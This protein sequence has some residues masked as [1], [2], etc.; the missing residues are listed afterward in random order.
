MEVKDDILDDTYIIYDI[1]ELKD[2]DIECLKSEIEF[3]NMYSQGSP[4][5]ILK[6]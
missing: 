3:H 4:V 1:D 5:P 6:T 2:I